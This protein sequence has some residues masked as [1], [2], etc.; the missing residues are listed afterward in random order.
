MKHAIWIWFDCKGLRMGRG[1]AKPITALPGLGRYH[2]RCTPAPS[3]SLESTHWFHLIDEDSYPCV[4]QHI[5]FPL[6][7]YL[8]L[9]AGCRLPR[10]RHQN[11]ADPSWKL[12]QFQQESTN[13]RLIRERRAK[14]EFLL[15]STTCDQQWTNYLVFVLPI[16]KNQLGVISR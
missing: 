15:F 1:A 4:K 6:Y 16:S 10:P 12:L 5:N 8:C 11:Q 13:S 3:E 2:S 14:T 9:L 7:R